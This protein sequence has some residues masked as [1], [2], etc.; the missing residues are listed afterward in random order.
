MKTITQNEGGHRENFVDKP[1]WVHTHVRYFNLILRV[2][3]F[4]S[5]IE[6]FLCSPLLVKQQRSDQHDFFYYTI[7][8]ALYFEVVLVALVGVL[9]AQ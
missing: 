3:V 6:E 8:V 7:P 5:T 1:I 2:Y 9:V 4:G